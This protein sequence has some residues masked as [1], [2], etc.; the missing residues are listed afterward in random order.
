MNNIEQGRKHH[1]EL[2]EQRSGSVSETTCNE[3][4]DEEMT[5]EEEEEGGEEE[6]ED[7]EN[8]TDTSSSH[9]ADHSDDRE[10]EIPLAQ[11]SPEIQDFIR[12][13]PQVAE[14]FQIISK[15]GE[16]MPSPNY[17][18]LSGTFSSVYKAV[19]LD[20]HLYD[21]SWD[22]NWKQAQKWSSP[23]IK[24]RPGNE[25]KA[26]TAK[27]VALK[28]I[29]VTSSP[30]RILNELELLHHL[31]YDSWLTLIS[32]G[33]TRSCPWSQLSAMKTKSLPSFH[34]LNIS[35][36]EYDLSFLC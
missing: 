32:E 12:Q 28:R 26:P 6:E 2:A 21:N 8:V 3:E 11:I 13:F 4:E 24:R 23:P 5:E 20:F 35:T 36:S 16:G 10:Q 17:L 19:D 31:K 1:E 27:Y 14:H 18:W 7:D 9:S 25:L 33:V 29:Y 34:I 22:G 30:A 15:I